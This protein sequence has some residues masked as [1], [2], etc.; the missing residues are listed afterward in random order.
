MWLSVP[1][2]SSNGLPRMEFWWSLP[3]LD[4]VYLLMVLLQVTCRCSRTAAASIKKHTQKSS[5]TYRVWFCMHA[6]FGTILIYVGA[7]MFLSVCLFSIDVA[8]FDDSSSYK[9]ALRAYAAA[10]LVHGVTVFGMLHKIPGH[11]YFSV[12]GYIVSGMLLLFHSC[13]LML[14]PSWRMAMV[15]WGFTNTFVYVRV[16]VGLFRRVGGIHAQDI[17]LVYTM[18]LFIAAAFSS[19]SYMDTGWWWA[20]WAILASPV[21][22]GP[23]LRAIHHVILVWLPRDLVEASPALQFVLQSTSLVDTFMPKDGA[24]ASAH[25]LVLP[26]AIVVHNNAAF[27][28]AAEI[29]LVQQKATPPE[30]DSAV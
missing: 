14:Q 10:G 1:Q 21:L 29:T 15:V 25:G 12:P 5:A 19:A 13:L 26:T 16:A 22:L 11:R 3:A 18:S 17:K 20:I 28:G 7:A 24:G 23:P 4:M 9:W 6:G 27:N 8:T 2:P 30:P